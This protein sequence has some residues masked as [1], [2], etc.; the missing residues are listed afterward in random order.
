VRRLAVLIVLVA[1]AVCPLLPAPA[2]AHTDP[3]PVVYAHRG[4]AGYAPE[5]TLGA[6]RMTWA[7]YAD[8][9]V[10]LELDTQLT[11]DGVPVV[12]HDDSLDRTTDCTGDVAAHTLAEL[13]PCN[14][15]LSF[16]G[17]TAFEP[18]PALEDVL[19]EGLDAGWRLMVEAKAIPGDA[20]F[21]PS[22]ITLADAILAAVDRTGFPADRLVVQSFWPPA[23]E[24]VELV[25]PAIPTALLTHSTLPGAP[26]DVGF[27][28]IENAAFATARSYEIAA[29]NY[30]APDLSADTVA[31]AHA[32]GR[33]VIPYTVD[34]AAAIA[35]VASYGV[36]GIIT[37]RPDVAFSTLG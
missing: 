9:N 4:G 32:L 16:A 7:A 11:A 14:A 24:R 36:D 31:A 20:G 26:K 8:D 33:Q 35:T 37:N 23:L 28:G 6:F 10:W 21:D 12:I 15:A 1:F 13:A 19:R 22:G 34:D 27:Y 2:T 3:A 30:D 25:A 18:V 5:N 29:P 17:W